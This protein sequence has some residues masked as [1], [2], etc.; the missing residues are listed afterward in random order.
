ML[1]G[2][3][4]IAVE[5]MGMRKSKARAECERETAELIERYKKCE[6]NQKDLLKEILANIGRAIPNLTKKEVIAGQRKIR[7]LHSKL[8]KDLSINKRSVPGNDPQKPN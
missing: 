2:F 7:A 5:F 8:A 4:V 6:I 3:I 1:Y